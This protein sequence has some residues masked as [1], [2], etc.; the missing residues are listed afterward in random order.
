M[1][2][3]STAMGPSHGPSVSRIIR[4]RSR[5]KTDKSRRAPKVGAH[6]ASRRARRSVVERIVLGRAAASVDPS[7]PS[8]VAGQPPCIRKAHKS[9]RPG[10]PPRFSGLRL[11]ESD[12]TP[13]RFAGDGTVFPGLRAGARD[14]RETRPRDVAGHPPHPPLSRSVCR[15]WPRATGIPGAYGRTREATAGVGDS[16]VARLAGAW[17]GAWMG[18]SPS[19]PRGLG[20]VL[21][22]R[23]VRT[24]PDRRCCREPCASGARSGSSAARS[25]IAGERFRLVV[26]P[27]RVP[28]ACHAASDITGRRQYP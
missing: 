12:G 15:L 18:P 11:S 9:C 19:T 2:L 3:R 21:A 14:K 22:H 17:R 8:G 26:R 23:P 20:A 10:K 4:L 28:G 5:S 24:A 27:R 7:R 25:A 13:I 16:G 1:L 6:G